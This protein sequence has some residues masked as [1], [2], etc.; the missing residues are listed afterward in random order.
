MSRQLLTGASALMRLLIAT[1][2]ALAPETTIFSDE[3]S[4]GSIS[5]WSRGDTNSASGADYWGIV[6]DGLYKPSAW[7]AAYPGTTSHTD[8]DT[9]R[10][11]HHYALNM[12]NGLH[13]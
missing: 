2:S 7:C 6:N 8:L 10:V 12:G 4:N 3:L 11:W 13:P 1:V 5:N 9:G